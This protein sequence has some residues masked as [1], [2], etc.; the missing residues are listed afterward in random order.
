MSKGSADTNSTFPE[1]GSVR[2]ISRRGSPIHTESHRRASM[3]KLAASPLAGSPAWQ[4]FVAP[5]AFKSPAAGSYASSVSGDDRMNVFEAGSS[6]PRGRT[7]QKQDRG[8]GSTLNAAES[9]LDSRSNSD[10]SDTKSRAPSVLLANNALAASPLDEATIIKTLSKHLATD[11]QT[12]LKLPGGD[13]TRDLYVIPHRQHRRSRSLSGADVE[14]ER[15]SSSVNE[16]RLPGGFRRE[17][18]QQ[19]NA[20]REKFGYTVVKPTVFTRNFL[21]FLSIYGHFAGEDLED[22]DYIACNYEDG[23]LLTD[24][25][26]P[27]LVGDQVQK[28]VGG[29]A[30]T[31]KSFFLL[32]KSFIGTGVLFLPKAFANGGLVYCI[33]T[34]LFFGVLSY[35]CYLIL[36]FSKNRT[37]VSSF[38]DIGLK[39]YGK[40]MKFLILIS[41]VLSQIGFVA[42]YIVFTAENLRAFAS[43]MF[44]I[45]LSIG[46]IVIFQGVI[47]GPM[48]L[49][50]N[51]TKL[52]LA[53]LVSNVFIMF[54]LVTIVYYSGVHLIENGVQD[55]Q[56]FNR[57]SWS[58]FIGVAIFAFEGI[59]LIIPV[60][61]SMKHPEQFPKVLLAVICVCSS[62]FICIGTLCYSSY[63]SKVQTVIILNLP[64]TSAA[65]KSIQLFYALA[66][67]LSQ[68]LQLLP[69]VRI[70]ESRV[71]KKRQSGKV[72]YTTKW[73][74]NGFRICCVVL[75]C[76]IAYFGSDNLDQFVSFVG[77][78]AC[79]PLVYMYPPMLHFKCCAKTF[80]MKSLDVALIL[81]GGVGL[82]YTT[83]QILTA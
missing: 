15:R 55:V 17:F 67:M 4:S 77:S 37:G 47:L 25:E 64:Q 39:L 62:L 23:K 31:M 2:S 50:R 42:A 34:L 16:M 52:S 75:T 83:Y 40:P 58:L 11:S 61:Q 9:A 12:S 81:L 60:E 45:H 78:F 10:S 69:A 79:I 49:I 28:P 29:T 22:E 5:N 76:L 73:L 26:T 66:I 38:G 65:V 80:W 6:T 48:S 72:D 59:G 56:R 19:K 30:S 63:G 46:S 24:E 7:T 13:I 51:I 71:F 33:L 68:P 36:I 27:L 57:D 41:I 54:G 43:G 3:A 21:E 70:I 82:V 35:W 18:I 8:F 53:A 1:S 32:L 74:K 44:G 20:Q 14:R